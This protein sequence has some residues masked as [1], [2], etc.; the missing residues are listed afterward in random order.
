M[1]DRWI[2]EH[3]DLLQNI[4]FA[5]VQADKSTPGLLDKHAEEGLRLVIQRRTAAAR[6]N[7]VKPLPEQG[8]SAA[9]AEMVEEILQMRKG[10]KSKETPEDVLRAL[11]EIRASVRRHTRIDGPRGYLNF[12]H[13]FVK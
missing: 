13:R 2:N 1:Q 4:E 12:I 3:L 11:K 5:I 8:K 6:G 10:L 7:S 9:V